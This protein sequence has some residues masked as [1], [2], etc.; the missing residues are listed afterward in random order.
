MCADNVIRRFAGIFVLLSLALGW[1]VSPYWC[2]FTAFVGFN[3]L[4]SSFTE[5]LS[6]GEGSWERRG[7]SDASRQRERLGNM[8]DWMI[9]DWMIE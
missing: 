4:Q 6:A 9:G 1:W 7:C 2:L 3:L 8:D 5:F